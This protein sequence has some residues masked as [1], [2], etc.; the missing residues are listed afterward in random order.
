MH[1]EV[2]ITLEKKKNKWRMMAVLHNYNPPNSD[3]SLV[4]EH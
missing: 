4:S 2:Y 1:A 3:I